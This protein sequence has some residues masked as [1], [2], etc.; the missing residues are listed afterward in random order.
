M[1]VYI[2][3]GPSRVCNLVN[4]SAWTCFIRHCNLDLRDDIE[5]PEKS[6]TCS[7]TELL[8]LQAHQWR[9]WRTCL[10][11][12]H[13]WHVCIRVLHICCGIVCIF[14]VL[15]VLCSM[16]YMCVYFMCV[17]FALCCMFYVLRLHIWCIACSV[18]VVYCI[19]GVCYMYVLFVFCV[20]CMS[21][22]SDAV[23]VR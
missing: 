7:L 14:G 3:Q 9:L 15:C 16:C 18:C 13:K 17:V 12:C 22:D 4:I 6:Q 5:T 19:C 23:E 21:T 20:C 10:I 8:I 11:L 2:T 1:L